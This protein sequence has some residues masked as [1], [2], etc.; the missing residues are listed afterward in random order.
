MGS[1]HAIYTEKHSFWGT[2]KSA[3]AYNSS[4]T[5]KDT[6]MCYVNNNRDTV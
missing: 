4:T 1:T 2:I 6:H 5:V 3:P